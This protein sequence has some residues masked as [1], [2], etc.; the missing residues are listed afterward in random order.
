[1]NKLAII[2][3]RGGS[4]RIPG[5][6][7]RNFLGKPMLAYP[8]TTALQSGL[9]DEVM[10]STDDAQIAEIAKQYG[11]SVPFLRSTLNANDTATTAAVLTEVINAYAE[12]HHKNFEWA[13]CIYPCTPLLEIAHLEKSF[14]IMEE[15]NMIASSFPIVAYSYP[16]WR[17]LALDENGFAMLNWNEYAST[18]SQD[19]PMA[20]HDAGMFYTFRVKSFLSNNNLF[21][22]CKPFVLNELDVQDIDTE[23]DWALAELKFKL[24]NNSV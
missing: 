12:R 17:S 21:T 23:T 16:I 7:I 10:V 20:Y 1:M 22:Q 11:A 6:N 5:K 14:S 2:P 13:C 9:F 24:K 19:L 18:R 8:I 4:K 3:A 15:N